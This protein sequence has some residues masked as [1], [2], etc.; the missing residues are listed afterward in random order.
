MIAIQP[1]GVK[2]T[3]CTYTA[4]YAENKRIAFEY[5]AALPVLDFLCSAK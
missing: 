4:M 2:K 3:R 1:G 5:K